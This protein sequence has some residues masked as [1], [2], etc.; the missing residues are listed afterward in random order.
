MFVLKSADFWD[1]ALHLS[2]AIEPKRFWICFKSILHLWENGNGQREQHPFT[3]VNLQK[4]I[5]GAAPFSVRWKNFLESMIFMLK[6]VECVCCIDSRYVSSAK[7]G[8]DCSHKWLCKM[9]AFF[10]TFSC[11]IL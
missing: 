1:I 9:G 3:T 10:G 11:K 2:Y 7:E 8:D 4:S 5:K 6:G